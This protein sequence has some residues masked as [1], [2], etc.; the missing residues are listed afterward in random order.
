[1]LTRKASAR[2][3]V[4]PVPKPTLVVRQRMPKRSRESWSRNSANCSRTFGIREALWGDGLRA[5]SSGG[6]HRPGGS[7][8]LPKTQVHAKAQAA[9][10]ALTPARCRKVKRIRQGFGPKRRS[11]AP[12][13]GGGNY[14]HPKVAKFL[15]GQVP[16]CTN[17]VTTSPLS[18]LETRRNCNTSKDARYAQKDEK[19]PGPLLYLGI[20]VRC[21]LC[22]IG[23]RLRSGSASFRGAAR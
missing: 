2:G 22:S 12:V 9:V 15:V 4:P 1:M 21:R 18:R 7:D 23:G 20:V 8:C 13:N 17:G 6:R 19:T 14:N 5:L 3:C 10:Y 16:T 11:Q